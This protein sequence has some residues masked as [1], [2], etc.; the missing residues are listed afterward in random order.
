M[1]SQPETTPTWLLPFRNILRLEEE[2]GFDNG[3][4]LGGL[5]KFL[6][7]WSSDMASCLKEP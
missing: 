3:A 7:R 4:V 6:Q 1:V 5:D 2:R